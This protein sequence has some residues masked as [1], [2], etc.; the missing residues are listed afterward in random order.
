MKN[1]VVL[2]TGASSGIG[3][4]CMLTFL[5]AGATVIGWAR[6]PIEVVEQLADGRL[7]THRID[8]RD[9]EAVRTC[10]ASLPQTLQHIDVL[11]NNAGLSRGLSPLH[12]GSDTDWDEMIDTNIKGLL[13]VTKCV[14]PGMIQRGSGTIIN[15][16]SIAGR[17]PYPGGNVYSATKAAV[18][19]I[20]DSL[21]IDINGTGVRVCSIDPGMVDTEFSLVRFHGDAQ[22]AQSVYQGLTPLTA[23]DV[24]DAALWVATRPPHVSVHDMLLMPTAQATATIVSRKV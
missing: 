20:S 2:V 7:Y 18:K 13:W 4:A 9:R 11:V 24:A 22:R 15:V 14:L 21:Q 6:R 16:A 1:K 17:Q 12:Q 10:Y 5:H 23:E 19:M 8:V 3:R